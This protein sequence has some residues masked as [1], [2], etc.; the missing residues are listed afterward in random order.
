MQKV[1]AVNLVEGDLTLTL[2]VFESLKAEILRNSNPLYLTL[3]LV[4]FECRS[5]TALHG[6]QRN[7]T[8]TLVVFECYTVRLLQVWPKII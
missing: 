8:L 6:A 7:L 5:G 2:V 4:V 3:T 1:R